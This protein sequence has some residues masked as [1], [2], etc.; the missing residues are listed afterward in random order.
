MASSA[1]RALHHRQLITAIQY[2]RM[3]N[4]TEV[5]S[6]QRVYQYRRSDIVWSSYEIDKII[7]FHPFYCSRSCELT[8]GRPALRRIQSRWAMKLK[9]THIN[10]HSA[11][12]STPFLCISSVIQYCVL[13]SHSID[14]K[15]CSNRRRTHSGIECRESNKIVFTMNS[16]VLGLAC[17]E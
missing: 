14:S 5:S 7:I 16:S 10:A 2:T 4:P 11:V 8:P 3:L 9:S 1:D 13:V 6:I 12:H 15:M 17:I